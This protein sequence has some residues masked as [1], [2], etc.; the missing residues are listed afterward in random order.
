[1]F[2]HFLKNFVSVFTSKS[3]IAAEFCFCIVSK[4]I[5]LSQYIYM[6]RSQDFLLIKYI[7]LG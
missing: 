4:C 1:M 3:N 5:G 7:V 6:F 2:C